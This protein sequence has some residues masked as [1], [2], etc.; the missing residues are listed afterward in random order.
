[1]YV[2]MSLC[3]RNEQTWTSS[4]MHVDGVLG[5]YVIDRFWSRSN[6]ILVLYQTT[7]TGIKSNTISGLVAFQMKGTSVIDL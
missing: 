3:L 2:H 5:D 4:Y 1:M 7:I 6:I